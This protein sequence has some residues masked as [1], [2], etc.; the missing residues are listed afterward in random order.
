MKIINYDEFVSLPKGTL[1]RE[2]EPC[3]F[4]ELQIKQD[5]INENNDWLLTRLDYLEESHSSDDFIKCYNKMEKGE[6]FN[7][8]IHCSER[9][10]MFDYDRKFLIYEKKDV[11]KLIELLKTCL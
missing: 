9:D 2:T 7:L 11:E 8:D 10:G 4:G 5:S 6:S 1:Y 3:W